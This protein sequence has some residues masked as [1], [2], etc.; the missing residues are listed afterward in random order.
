MSQAVFSLSDPAKNFAAVTPHNTTNFGPA[1]APTFTRGLYVGGAG[2]VVAV[3]E[4]DTAVTFAAVPAGTVLPIRCKR[5]NS[6]N[7]TA[8]AIVRLW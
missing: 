7:T 5:V 8:S 1:T 3:G 4:D 6:T 2:D